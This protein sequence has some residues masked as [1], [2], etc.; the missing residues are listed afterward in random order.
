MVL[1]PVQLQIQGQNT[2]VSTKE[3]LNRKSYFFLIQPFVLL[4]S[5]GEE[6]E[7]FRE[8]RAN[9]KSC[10]VWGLQRFGWVQKNPEQICFRHLGDNSICDTS[11]FKL[12]YI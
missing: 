4:R 5:R 10:H 12:Y 9:I 1:N 3:Q 8:H 7:S 11:T 6:A 2:D